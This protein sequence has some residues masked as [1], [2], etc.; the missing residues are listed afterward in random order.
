M[1]LYLRNDAV[2]CVA[3]RLWLVIFAEI[4]RDVQ[5]PRLV[6]AVMLTASGNC[7]ALHNHGRASPSCAEAS[8]AV[9][10]CTVVR[11]DDTVGQRVAVAPRW[12][13]QP[14]LRKHHNKSIGGAYV[15]RP[16][17]ARREWPRRPRLDPTQMVRFFALPMATAQHT[18]TRPWTSHHCSFTCS[19]SPF[20]PWLLVPS[21]HVPCLEVPSTER[22]K[23]K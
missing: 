13:M 2:R 12:H 23:R 1:H 16:Q 18:A 3:S 19:V 4:L 17:T 20:S 15:S 6:R 9:S 22:V 8:C 5:S 11:Y 14:M 7:V 10:Q 21:V